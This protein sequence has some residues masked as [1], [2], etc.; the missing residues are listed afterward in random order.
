VDVEALPAEFPSPG[1]RALDAAAACLARCADGSLVL[2]DGLAFGV[3]PELARRHARRLRLVAL[4]HHPL[5]A[6]TGSDAAR[7]RALFESERD[8]LACARLVIVTS[9]T[10]AAQMHESGLV[11]RLPAVVEPGVQ[12]APLREPPRETAGADAAADPARLLCVATLTPR[13]NHLGLVDALATL[14]EL[15]WTL[16]CYG[17][18]TAHPATVATVRARIA[19]LGLGERIALCGEI[20]GEALEAVRRDSDV[21]VLPSLYEGYGMAVAEAIVQGLPVIATRTGSAAA[22]VGVDAGVLVEP[23][24]AASLRAALYEL[25][26]DSA[27]RE[28]CAAAARARA[29]HLADWDAAAARFAALLAGV[30]S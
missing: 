21:F 28:Q 29:A 5:H 3:L 26:T 25:L 27:R 15:P 2:V 30:A 14:R 6:E 4:V 22:L 13:K 19:A 1:P 18:L 10:T 23:G 9:A 20:E 11:Q 8:A 24:D 16:R 17:S 12:C 7:Q